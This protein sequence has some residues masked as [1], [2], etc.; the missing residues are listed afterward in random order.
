MGREAD[1]NDRD[2]AAPVLVSALTGEGLSALISRIEARI[3]RS[4][5]TFAVILPPEDGAAL[6]WL[7]ENAEV[8][9]RRME[10]GGTLHLAIR[11]APEKEPRFLNRFAGA[12]HL[13][14]AE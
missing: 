4:R 7:Y 2:S 1:R 8:L 10:E 5:S 14:K 13:H 11:I 3:A 12:R 9:D 6:N